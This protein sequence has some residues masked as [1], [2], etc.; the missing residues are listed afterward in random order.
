MLRYD[1]GCAYIFSTS[2][3]LEHS[4]NSFRRPMVLQ[5]Y[6]GDVANLVFQKKKK[7]L[8]ETASSFATPA[9][10][11]LGKLPMQPPTAA[12][13]SPEARHCLSV[14][15]GRDRAAS[16]SAGRRA[17]R[18][19]S[20]AATAHRGASPPLRIRLR[21]PSKEYTPS[22]TLDAAAQT[23]TPTAAK[24]IRNAPQTGS[25]LRPRLAGG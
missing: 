14:R 22:S 23:F 11:S 13:A 25:T 19:Q 18:D 24:T 4:G 12:V 20:S 10:T 5:S 15:G 8:T 7:K 6:V 1:I 21:S 9:G 3:S 2:T 16:A 17:Q